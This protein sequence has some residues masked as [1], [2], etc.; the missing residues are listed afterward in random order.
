[1]LELGPGGR[2]DSEPALSLEVIWIGLEAGLQQGLDNH[3]LAGGD[4]GLLVDGETA[5]VDVETD[6][7]T[8]SGLSLLP[9]LN[10]FGL[11]PNVVLGFV[12]VGIPCLD[13]CGVLPRIFYLISDVL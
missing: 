12:P 7:G 2:S 13:D 1:M 6:A 3:E 10:P 4:V 5:G 9:L 11:E 8:C